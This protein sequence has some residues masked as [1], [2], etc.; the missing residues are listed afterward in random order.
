MDTRRKLRAWELLQKNGIQYLYQWEDLKYLLAPFFAQNA[1][2]QQLFYDIFEA[3]QEECKQL[4]LPRQKTWW[5]SVWE[6]V[7]GKIGIVT[8]IPV[9]LLLAFLWALPLFYVHEPGTTRFEGP[10]RKVGVPI[11]T[12]AKA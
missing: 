4:E 6:S 12:Q 5:E 10:Q 9:M 3:F 8:G 2:Q 1:K 11:R 7:W